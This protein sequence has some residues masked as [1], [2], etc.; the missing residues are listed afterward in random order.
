[1]LADKMYGDYDQFEIFGSEA[2]AS[3][4]LP[5]GPPLTAGWAA[6][7]AR[8]AIFRGYV[9]A[10]TCVRARIH[11]SGSGVTSAASGW[12]STL[13]ILSADQKLAGKAG[14]PRG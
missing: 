1:M 10:D 5:P 12:D 2:G 3:K 11:K 8:N 13:D 9:A 4:E 14:R 6:Q 7:L